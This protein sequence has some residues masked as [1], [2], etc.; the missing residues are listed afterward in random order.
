MTDKPTRIEVDC[1]TGESRVLELT[2][3]EMAQL[4]TDR[5]QFEAEQAAAEAAAAEK[6]V[7]R[8]ALLDRLGMTEEEA[9]LLLNS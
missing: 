2:D 5:L 8:Q 4:E 7:A 6:A 9:Q 3:E 1:T